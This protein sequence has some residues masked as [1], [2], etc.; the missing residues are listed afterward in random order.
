MLVLYVE[1]PFAVFRTFTAGWYRPTATFITP[2]AAY[3]L[4][5]NLAGIESRLRE[6]DERHPGSVPASLTRTGLPKVRIALGAAAARRIRGMHIDL[7]ES[8]RF[9][10]VATIFQQL[11]NYPVGDEKIADPD[12]P[13]AKASKWDI[14]VRRTKYSKF[15]IAPVRREVLVGLKA[16]IAIDGSAELEA[17]VRRALE[18]EQRADRYGLP[19]LGDNAFLPD[20]VE[21]L[22]NAP[23]THWY[24]RL[25]TDSGIIRPRTT[26]LTQSINR[27]EMSRTVS[28]LYAPTP[29]PITEPPATAWTSMESLPDPS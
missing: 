24:E 25:G 22:D 10:R 4:I 18:G 20:H 9:P 3:G 12:N 15:N 8:E 1:A 11:H 7:P 27:A 26:R 16:V 17:D 2:S 14:G 28:H 19:F 13:G 29:K 21:P 23:P 5:L 6:E